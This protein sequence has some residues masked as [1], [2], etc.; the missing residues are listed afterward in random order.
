MI[1]GLA[2]LQSNQRAVENY[3]VFLSIRPYCGKKYR[4]STGGI[5]QLDCARSSFIRDASLERQSRFGSIQ[6]A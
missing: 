1:A 2:N 4:K 6:A 5:S 3:Y